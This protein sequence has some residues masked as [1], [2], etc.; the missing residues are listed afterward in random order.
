VPQTKLKVNQPGDAYER[1]AD[2]AAEQVMRMT[3]LGPSLS[4]DEDEAKSSLMRKQ[5]IEPPE[6][7]AAKIPSIPPVVHAALNS[8]EGQSLYTTTSAFHDAFPHFR[9]E[10]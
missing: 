7:V 1:E 8:G 9:I 4:D 10:S 2:Q 6:H 3:D 5:S